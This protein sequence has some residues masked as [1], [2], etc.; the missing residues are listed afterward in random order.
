MQRRDIP[1]L[2]ISS[3]RR[4]FGGLASQSR[5]ILIVT[6]TRDIIH[7]MG[8]HNP[9]S[10]RNSSTPNLP[11]NIGLH[12]MD[13]I[14]VLPASPLSETIPR[15]NLI[16]RKSSPPNFLTLNSSPLSPPTPFSPLFTMPMTPPPSPLKSSSRPPSREST[17]SLPVPIHT[18]T[19]PNFPRVFH[20]NSS[21]AVHTGIW[22]NT[23]AYGEAP[24]FSR[25]NMGSDVV[26]PIPARSRQAKPIA[27]VEPIL[28]VRS[29]SPVASTS[30]S[31]ADF[32]APPPFR[33]NAH[34]R[35]RSNSTSAVLDQKSESKEPVV[36]DLPIS[37]FTSDTPHS[38]LGSL[39]ARTKSVISRSKHFVHSRAQAISN[40]DSILGPTVQRN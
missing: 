5:E 37:E 31:K 21:P 6:D 19:P 33:R 24:Q 18:P 28:V 7:G 30:S 35:K 13:T 16:S 3:R 15:S 17:K 9:V 36:H 12:T 34:N 23:N 27:M 11:L 32:L 22:Q 25:H 1:P 38:G 2:T 39:R 40:V 4:Q 8:S 26:M 29:P 20:R 10:P 14:P